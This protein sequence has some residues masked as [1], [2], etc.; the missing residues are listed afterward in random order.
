M[1][2]IFK[3]RYLPTGNTK[4]I[5]ITLFSALMLFASHLSSAAPLTSAA[6]SGTVS[7][8][9]VDLSEKSLREVSLV[10]A[11]VEMW[12]EQIEAQGDIMPWREISVGTEIGGLRLIS[13]PAHVGDLVKK[14]QVLA[15]LNPATVE[16]ELA[17]VNAQLMEAQAT[18]AQADAT[19]TRAKRLALSGGVSK[20]DLTHYETQWQT[21]TARLGAIRAQMKTQQR[22][23]D[24]AT[25]VAPDDGVISSSFATEGAIVHAGDELFRLIRQGRLEWRAE[26][27]GETLLKLS[28]GLDVMIK[29]PLGPAIKACIR[30]VSPTI[31]LKT[32]NGLVYVDLP[33]DS[34]F[35]AG[36]FVSGTLAIKRKALV[37]PSSS[38]KHEGDAYQVLTA[39][40][41]NKIEALEV[42][43]GRILGDQREITSGLDEHSK[44]IARDVE[45]LKP[46]DLVNLKGPHLNK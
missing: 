23:L 14:G 44:V 26:V 18:L 41:D 25:L 17:A 42:K 16:A 10:S 7:V 34:N 46:G 35:K 32:R 2:P 19:L 6:P 12:P 33:P 9:H 22:K 21:A 28:A 5:A 11:K 29:S 36:L 15:Q 45:F 31:D 39:N 13:V 1:P 27:K 8:E 38:V 43:V 40:L 4:A 24:S 20:Q 30:Q 37:V 3:F